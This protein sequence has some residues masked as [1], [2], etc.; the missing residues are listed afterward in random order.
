VFECAERTFLINSLLD[1]V[2][3]KFFM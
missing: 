2:D 3:F 1:F